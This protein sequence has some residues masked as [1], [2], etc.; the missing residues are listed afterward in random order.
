MTLASSLASGI[1]D[2]IGPTPM[3]RLRALP[4]ANSAQVW[5]K[6]EQWSP[7]GS[8]MDRTAL[9]MVNSAE[10]AGLIRPHQSTI[11]VASSGNTGIALALACRIK[12]YRLLVTMPASMSLERR[13]LIV[14]YGAELAL[15]P[16][17][18]LL[19]G[20]RDQAAEICRSRPGHVL[21]DQ[22]A[23]PACAEAH[24]RTTA[25]EL[26]AQ[27]EG[28]IDALVVGVGS[29]A[30]LTGVG[31][32]LKAR[33]PAMAIVAVEPARCAVLSG[34][35]IGSHSIQGLGVGFV[36]DTLDRSLIDEVRTVED[37]QAQQT[38]VRLAQREGLLVGL[39][40]GANVAIALEV[41][42]ALGRNRRVLTF[43]CD[44]GERYFSLEG[45]IG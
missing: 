26:L 8:I 42:R 41:A 2:R 45:R 43:L 19:P 11:V 18:R 25:V 23:H 20:A 30:T 4:E 37:E 6:C 40:S 9:A 44:T 10:Q 38:K 13:Q 39:S 14:Q 17:E 27:V 24:R 21:L 5:C 31:S 12:G 1:L 34:G 7:S 32:V 35:P 33:F 22:F 15:T 28:P 29:G 16:A 36:P 3:L